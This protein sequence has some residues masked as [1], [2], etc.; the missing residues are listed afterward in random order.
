M[1]KILSHKETDRM[2]GAHILGSVSAFFR[3]LIGQCGMLMT[4]V[5]F[6][7]MSAFGV[8][9]SFY[10]RNRSFQLL[11]ETNKQPFLAY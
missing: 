3:L 4:V 5:S 9:N 11:Q 2:L 10:P 8:S 7:F 1:V 6:V